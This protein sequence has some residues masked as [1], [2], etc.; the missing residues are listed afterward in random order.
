MSGR[1]EKEEKQTETVEYIILYRLLIHIRGQMRDD[2]K[3]LRLVM[4]IIK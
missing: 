1:R 3:I 2:F 4:E